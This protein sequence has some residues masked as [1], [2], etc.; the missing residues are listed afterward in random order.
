[1]YC[2]IVWYAWTWPRPES[3]VLTGADLGLLNA[4]QGKREEAKRQDGKGS[5]GV[6]VAGYVSDTTPIK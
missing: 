4:R 3:G 1:M 2:A 6:Y 5:E